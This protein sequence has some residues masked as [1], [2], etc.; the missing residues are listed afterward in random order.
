M[1]AVEE[2]Q[3]RRR[4]KQPL[5]AS[6]G[7][8]RALAA[9]VL[10]DMLTSNESEFALLSTGQPSD[11]SPTDAAILAYGKKVGVRLL[12]TLG[13]DTRRSC[14]ECESFGAMAKKI[15]KHA[16]CPTCRR[17]VKGEATVRAQV[18]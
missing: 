12:V 3:E 5:P 14:D 8:A 15:I 16:T 10:A 18:A 13:D 2:S 17:H 9:E 6:S 4:S 1:E 7:A 11:A